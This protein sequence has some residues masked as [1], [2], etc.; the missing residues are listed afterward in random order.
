[1]TG[2]ALSIVALVAVVGVVPIGAT[3]VGASAR[4]PVQGAK[5]ASAKTETV[6]RTFLDNGAPQV[7]DKR[8]VTVSVSNLQGL[9]DRQGVSVTWSGAHPTGGIV[10]D[11]NSAT[12]ATQQE[13]PMV[14]MQCRGIDSTRVP[15][16]KRLS[17]TSCWTQTSSERF[18]G[19]YNSSLPPW[20]LDRYASA[21]DR[22]VIVN[23]P[24][25]L[26]PEC[27]G[28]GLAEHWLPFVAASGKT[29]YSGLNGCG[30]VPPE[31]VPFSNALSLPGNTTYSASSLG[32]KGAATFNV[33]TDQSNASLGCSEK[34]PCSLVVIP[35]MGI[36]C[37]VDA[38]G[39]P[40]AEV[41]SPAELDAAATRCMG[42]GAYAPGQTTN[43]N[44]RANQ[45]VSGALWWAA[46]N[47]RNRIVFPLGFAP[48]TSTCDI[49]QGGG[50]Q[51]YGSELMIQATDQWSP[52]FCL[53]P[54]RTPVQHVQT[55][56]P[57]A[58]SLLKNGS[59]DAAMTSRP[60]DSPGYGRPVVHAPIAL[61]GFGIT[62]QVDGAD[63]R[64]LPDLRLT[65]RLLAKLLTQ[66]YPTIPDIKSRYTALSGN[67]MNI[68]DDPEFLALNPKAKQNSSAASAATI[69][70]LSSDSDVMY[71]LTSYIEA[72]PEA[73]AWLDGKPD[74]WGMVVNPNYKGISLPVQTWPI[75]DTFNPPGLYTQGVNDCLYQNPV[76]YLPLVAAPLTRLSYIA[77]SM[78]F[79]L[80]NSQIV[81]YLP[82]S[83]MGSTEGAKLTAVGRQT[84]GFRYML[85]VTSLADAKRYNIPL[86]SLETTVAKNAPGA[87]SSAQGR[88][89]VRPSDMSLVA[90]S[91]LLV[92]DKATLSWDLPYD[93]FHSSKAASDA[94]P[95]TMLVYADIPTSGLAT[96]DANALA[97]WL[98]FVSSSGQARGD[99]V[100]QLPAGYVPMTTKSGLGAL[101]EYSQRSVEA[102]RSQQGEVPGLTAQTASGA[103]R[104]S[105]TANSSGNGG[106]TNGYGSTSSGGNGDGSSGSTG[107][108]SAT[109]V[110]AGPAAASLGVTPAGPAGLAG[111][112]L[113]GVLLFALL[114]G[115]V[116]SAT[117]FRARA[118]GTP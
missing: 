28:Q 18:T 38:A 35:I 91:R 75:L 30:G 48:S 25:K 20:R 5:S 23:R 76:P 58:R 60:A 53:D 105:G 90:A 26:P 1:M 101:A 99:S 74:P 61:T 37:D 34:V 111:L 36:S 68:S 81:C 92:P 3:A 19:D 98:D 113:P 66:S 78:Q 8:T 69:L 9:R 39:L 72:D 55:G 29:Y 110:A 95:G 114:V 80:S 17:P 52:R 12:A 16:A 97:D 70:S 82:S 27:S 10:S 87:F 42:T 4:M 7:V 108:A 56:E 40:A 57:Q 109:D 47:W 15:A 2:R 14:L 32:G 83:N 24:K 45:A 63:D 6:T 31:G 94:Y 21:A 44:I 96:S 112:A 118:K 86:A 77:L 115:A 13:Y 67:P 46:S 88:T 85:G 73:R 116:A 49:T 100:G 107:P 59:I 41:P 62:Y 89:F 43:P 22:D 103:P 65:P 50:V 71:A 106:S 64:Q 102:V 33:R 104:S 93:A 54:A 84:P 11:P 117:L 79:A 51:I